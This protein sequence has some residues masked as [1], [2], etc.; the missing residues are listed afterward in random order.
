MEN[1]ALFFLGAARSMR[2]TR[3]LI[4]LFTIAIGCSILA[5][6]NV[7]AQEQYQSPQPLS[8]E[9][10]NGL[11]ATDTEREQSR[12]EKTRAITQFQKTKSM[13]L[14]SDSETE[15]GQRQRTRLLNELEI[16]K[17]AQK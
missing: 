4:F 15:D 12:Q 9:E 5:V 6:S 8:L 10:Q 14:T 2:S 13:Y 11:L 7:S 17:S 16:L 3:Y 1:K